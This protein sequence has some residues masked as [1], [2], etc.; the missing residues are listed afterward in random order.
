MYFFNLHV[1]HHSN[2]NTSISARY[3]SLAVPG[4]MKNSRLVDK[5]VGGG[6]GI[7]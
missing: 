6:V 2:R 5:A 1:K 7:G 4:R 3:Q